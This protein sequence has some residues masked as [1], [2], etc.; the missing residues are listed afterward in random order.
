M[1][2]LNVMKSVLLGGSF[3]L[4]LCAAVPVSAVVPGKHQ[5]VKTTVVNGDWVYDSSSLDRKFASLDSE[6][7]FK[8]PDSESSHP[9]NL[10]LELFDFGGNYEFRLF[11]RDADFKCPT[12]IPCTI[13]VSFDGGVK[14]KV[15]IEF[16]EGLDNRHVNAKREEYKAIYTALKTAKTMTIDASFVGVGVKSYKFRVG[17]LKWPSPK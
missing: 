6:N 14:K 11:N 7:G 4:S 2:K 15:Q 17:G 5:H 10:G 3:A 9:T 13:L 1:K 8:F 12:K 16:T